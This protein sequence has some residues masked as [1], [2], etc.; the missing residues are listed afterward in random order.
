MPDNPHRVST[1]LGLRYLQSFAN[2]RVTLSYLTQKEQLE[3]QHICV[4]FYHHGTS[5]VQRRIRRSQYLFTIFHESK[6]NANII[7]VT[8]SGLV[9]LLTCEDT[10]L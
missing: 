1:A 5:R 2:M 7:L 9:R 4:W 3:T 6:F 10:S 8:T